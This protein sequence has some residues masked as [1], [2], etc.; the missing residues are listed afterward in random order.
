MRTIGLIAGR[1]VAAFPAILLALCLAAGA[2]AGNAW[3][4]PAG[5]GILDLRG[6][7]PNDAD[8]VELEGDWLVAWGRLAGADTGKPAGDE[9]AGWT[10]MRLP[11]IWNGQRLADGTVM[12][13]AG[14]ATFRL[15]VLLPADSPALTLQVPQ[16]KSASRVWLNGRPV[17]EAG[18][19][20]L[21][22][23][24]EVPFMATRFV[25]LPAGLATA[26]LAIEVSNHFHHEGG[27]PKA[28]KL[29]RGG[30]LVKQWNLRVL[31]NAGVVFSLIM[32]GLYVAAFS[33]PG[34][35]MS[36]RFLTAL[37]ASMAV[38][39]LC[40]GELLVQHLPGIGA[41][42]V[43]RLE[44]L[45]I[46][47]FLPVYYH[48]LRELYPGYMHRWVGRAMDAAGLAGGLFVILAEPMVFTRFRDPA[49]VL[50][51]V[52]V[53][54]FIWRIAV[55]ARH[56][57][58]G[59]G[60]LLG[61]VVVLMASVVHDALMYAHVYQSVDLVFFGVLVFMFV[62]ALVL[63]RRVL[64]A[65]DDVQDL[66]RELARLNEGLERQVEERTRA[67]RDQSAMVE[68]VLRGAKERAEADAERKS[69][70]L[71]HLSHEVR[72]PMNAVLG[73]V[74][75][76]L[77]DGP[78]EP[79][80]QRLRTVESAG[81]RLVSL[82]DEVLDL[83]RL[84][85]GKVVL[86]PEPSDLAAL[87]GDVVALARP[88]A[89]EK[90][91]ALTLRVGAG[92]RPG[93]GVD[94]LRLQQVLLNLLS[95]AVKFTDHGGILVTVDAAP[96]DA[97]R[98]RVE[99]AVADSGPG[100][101]DA[102][103]AAIF[104]NFTRI[105]VARIDGRAGQGGTGLG[106]AIVQRLA[107]AMGG[108]VAVGDR[109]GGGAVFTVAI[110]LG[111]AVLPAPVAAA[112]RPL[113]PVPPLDI[114]MVEDAPEN[115]AVLAELLAPAGHR[116]VAAE[117]GEEALR[118]LAERRFDV[119]LMDVRLAGMDGVEATRRIRA[120]DD[121]EAAL[122]PVIAV[123]ANVSPEDEAAYRAAGFDEVLAKPLDPDL[124]QDALARHAPLTG[125]AAG[126]DAPAPVLADMPAD[127]MAR[128][129]RVF[130]AACREQATALEAAAGTGDRARIAAVAHRLKGSAAIYGFETLG[131]AAAALEAAANNGTAA[132]AGHTVRV[133]EE[134]QRALEAMDARDARIDAFPA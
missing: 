41:G 58:F 92:V 112:R 42:L 28:L 89:E 21:E 93:Y 116:V 62:H 134:L 39:L 109:P 106:L 43:F 2:M 14:A 97:D 63:G 115:R 94:R 13:S 84:E 128:L 64:K 68:T 119:V 54:Y 33:R 18:R 99:I 110:P 5:N 37:L 101:P 129:T 19:P 32:L 76:L 23:G 75:L 40:T 132:L 70:F 49:S 122:T 87:V 88:L 95:N 9:P 60:L 82:L 20:S 85:A 22:A 78:T 104:E 10:P 50:L 80:A 103:K 34:T 96:L 31:T 130:A 25:T 38:R 127:R 52:S 44:Y 6:W 56:R 72:T 3:A 59:A 124:L 55:A 71:A 35:A 77:R 90:A 46:Y 11:R 29:D 73:M 53:L 125:T 118:R 26:D 27:V 86:K 114:L 57:Q 100:V 12:G 120:L 74:R 47:L 131:A 36:H 126:T 7:G 17:A 16:I 83:A 69:R 123:T 61:G 98:D 108:T 105:D 91:L 102:A 1:F 113:P 133:Q 66:S 111:R 79:Q 65:F 81:R 48:V 8:V 51:G 24:G 121:E 15:R 117:S 67:L 107:A 30:T 45:P 4:A